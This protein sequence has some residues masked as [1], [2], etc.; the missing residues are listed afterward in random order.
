MTLK[1]I[2]KRF[3]DLDLTQTQIARREKVSLSAVSQ[4]VR[5]VMVSRR[6]RR[7]VAEALG[8]PVEEIWPPNKKDAA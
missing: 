3:I 1:E 5:G 4:V 2:K 7:A 8:V 6:L